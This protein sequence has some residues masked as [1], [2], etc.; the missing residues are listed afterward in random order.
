MRKAHWNGEEKQTHLPSWPI[1]SS[2]ASPY[3]NRQQLTVMPWRMSC[4][5]VSGANNPRLNRHTLQKEVL[6]FASSQNSPVSQHSQCI[7]VL[8]DAGAPARVSHTCHRLMSWQESEGWR[9]RARGMG[10][11]EI[12]CEEGERKTRR[13]QKEKLHVQK[14]WPGRRLAP[15]QRGDPANRKKGTNGRK[16]SAA[17]K[18]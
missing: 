8:L 12:S 10:R 9:K 3:I 17:S 2:P 6:G 14:R 13:A 7:S 5:L 1:F 15:G 11:D 4:A 16:Y 18:C